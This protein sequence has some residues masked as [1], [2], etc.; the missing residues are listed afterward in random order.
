MARARL[1]TVRIQVNGVSHETEVDTARLLVDYLRDRLGLT[2]TRQ[3]CETSRCGACAVLMNGVTVRACTLFAVQAEG[4][5]VETIEGLESAGPHPVRSALR[6][7]GIQP[8]DDCLAGRLV[9]VEALLRRKKRPMRGEVERALE[10][11]RCVCGTGPS[12]V[13]AVLRVT[14]AP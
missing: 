12:V 5:S 4:T 10:G 9:L 6:D 13:D 14:R 11:N 2:G 8:C 1:E 7:A 3:A